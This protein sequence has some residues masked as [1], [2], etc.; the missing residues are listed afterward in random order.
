M[1]AAFL[2]QAA[3]APAAAA[4]AVDSAIGE[5]NAV[6]MAFFFVFI[7][8]TLGITC[9]AA[10]RTADHRAVLRRRPHGQRR[11]ERLRARRRL[12]ERGELPRHR[13]ARLAPPA[14]TA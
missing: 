10:R 8:I 11:P 3:T 2:L 12:H 6:A 14:S 9:W 7:A 4:P 5:P 1:T 13:R